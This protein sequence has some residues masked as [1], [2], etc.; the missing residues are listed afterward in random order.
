MY[1][2]NYVKKEAELT[3]IFAFQNLERGVSNIWKGEVVKGFF[4]GL[5][6]PKSCWGFHTFPFSPF[7]FPKSGKVLSHFWK[8]S[9]FIIFWDMWQRI[10]Y[11]SQI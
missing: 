11:K 1:R 9:F 6:K 10:L 7:S 3:G 4:G 8:G 5:E 2:Y